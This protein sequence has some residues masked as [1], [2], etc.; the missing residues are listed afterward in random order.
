MEV[1]IKINS[2]ELDGPPERSG[3]Y[4]AWYDWGAFVDMEYSA[5]LK[6]WNLFAD[7]DRSCE[8]FPAFWAEVPRIKE[9]EEV[10]EKKYREVANG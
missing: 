8:A 3:I 9:I 6:G 7:G 5:E 2:T 10:A 1:T 4:L